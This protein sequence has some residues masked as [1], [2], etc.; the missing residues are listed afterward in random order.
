[1]IGM[2]SNEELLLAKRELEVLWRRVLHLAA[3]I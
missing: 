2:F 3:H 1:M